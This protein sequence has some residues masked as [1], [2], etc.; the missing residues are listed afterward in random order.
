[1]ATYYV[2]KNGSDANAGT[3]PSAA[4]ATIG[5]ALGA[6]GIADTTV[7]NTVWVGGGVYRET[8]SVGM[9]NPTAEQIIA[10]DVTGANTGDPGQ[11]LLTAYTTDDVTAPSASTALVLGGTNFLTF[12]NLS[13]QGG[14][15]SPTVLSGG[16][17]AGNDITFEDCFFFAWEAERLMRIH[18]TAGKVLNWMFDRCRF[19]SGLGS[20]YMIQ[21]A[22]DASATASWD[23]N[24]VFRNCIMGPGSSSGDLIDVNRDGG[25]GTFR[26]GGVK[27]YN[28]TM[29]GSAYA[30]YVGPDQAGMVACVVENSLILTA[31]G[32]Q[33]DSGTISEDWNLF[34]CPTPR[35][36]VTA[37]SNSKTAYAV[38]IH[39]GQQVL[40]GFQLRP[41][42]TPMPGSVL[43][44]FGNSANGPAVDFSN[45]PRP[46]GG[47]STLKAVGALER[48]DTAVLDSSTSPISY[49]IDGPGDQDLQIPVAAVGTSISLQ[50]QY[51]TNH[52]TTT[53]PQ[54]QLLANGE[55][56]VTAQTLTADAVTDVWLTM[57]FSQFTPTGGSWVTVRLVN[58]AGAG[59]GK[60]WFT[61]PVVV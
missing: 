33:T 15:G 45:R 2:R 41:F 14:T 13:I 26:G 8:T 21:F 34:N 9:T 38:G 32:L 18:A 48:H 12:R 19:V 30:M 25:S 49:R 22:V 20:A 10:G 59:S 36:G 3:S 39:M 5:K 6:A 54:V 24:A 7:T 60:A 56:G 27:V 50:I 55:V 29:L 47:Q 17:N 51:D 42:C 16:T 31:T 46:A 4:W 11:V 1:M 40:S 43:L 61:S 28:C 53:P 44:G 35:V 58:R 23:M 52:G 37:G 57:T